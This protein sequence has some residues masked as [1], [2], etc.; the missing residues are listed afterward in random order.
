MSTRTIGHTCKCVR[1]KL[2]LA[3]GNERRARGDGQGKGDSDKGR[4]VLGDGWVR[5]A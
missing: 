1:C 5:W 4:F 3:A 2:K